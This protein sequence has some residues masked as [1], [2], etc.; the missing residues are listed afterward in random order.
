MQLRQTIARANSRP[1]KSPALRQRQP[2]FNP[3]AVPIIP[4]HPLEKCSLWK[5]FFYMDIMFGKVIL[6]I[7]I[8]GNHFPPRH[9]PYPG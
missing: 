7:S 5:I 4:H 8:R 6:S 3:L 2:H 9:C 1:A